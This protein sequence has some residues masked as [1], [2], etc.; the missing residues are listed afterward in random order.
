MNELVK[1]ISVAII[2]IPFALVVIWAGGLYFTFSIIIIST[3]AL[4]EYYKISETKSISPN[5][6]MGITSGIILQLIIFIGD[7]RINQYLVVVF[8]IFLLLTLVFELFSR[9]LNPITNIAVTITG[10]LYVSLM[11]GCLIAI[12]EFYRLFNFNDNYITFLST[13]NNEQTFA[14]F[15][16]ALFVTVWICDSAA[17]FLGK[18]FG[19]HKLYPSV[20]PKKSWEGAIAGFVASIIT[21]TILIYLLIPEFP[22]IHSIIIGLLIGIF[23]QIGDLAE[24]LLKRDA[25]IKDSSTILPGHGGFLDRFDSIIFVAPILFIYIYVLFCSI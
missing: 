7:W 21:F 12:R 17:Y 8:L 9:K 16:F 20:S 18:A 3:L 25:G 22:M 4:W 14:Y 19:I 1:R 24:S 23:G 10:P 2:G 6:I 15:V 11:L 5:K 13:S